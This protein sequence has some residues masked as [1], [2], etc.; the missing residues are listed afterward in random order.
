VSSYP[1]IVLVY[2]YGMAFEN[3]SSYGMLQKQDGCHNHLK[4]RKIVRFS[5]DFGK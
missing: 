1:V 2:G 4:T 5:D 3:W